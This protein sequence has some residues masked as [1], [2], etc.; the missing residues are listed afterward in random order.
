ML[1]N[2]QCFTA[3]HT[4]ILSSVSEYMIVDYAF[5]I[6]ITTLQKLKTFVL[7]TK[8]CTHYFPY[9]KS[10]IN[11]DNCKLSLNITDRM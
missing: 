11:T 10:Y 6:L 7:E 1:E 8:M 5:T 9:G 4:I 3:F 2:K